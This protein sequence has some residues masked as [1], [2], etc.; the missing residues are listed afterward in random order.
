MIRELSEVLLLSYEES[1]CT[2]VC[3]RKKRES[4]KSFSLL[5]PGKLIVTEA[6]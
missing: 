1:K 3:D 6:E 2:Y 4:T 5:V